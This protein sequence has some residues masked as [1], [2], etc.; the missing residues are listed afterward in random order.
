MKHEILLVDAE[1]RSVRVIGGALRTAGYNVRIAGNGV[2]ALEKVEALTPDVILSDAQLPKLH[3]YA[4]AAKLKERKASAHIPVV[5]LTPPGWSEE[6]GRG[7]E[8]GIADY[9][10]KPV[11]VRELIACV[12]LLV[13]RGARQRIAAAVS[14]PKSGR[15]SGSTKDMSVLDL[16]QT[17]EVLRA[18]GVAHV[19]RGESEAELS[20]RDGRAVDAKLGRLRGEE[21]IYAALVWS[22]ASFDVE[23]KAVSRDD[24]IDRSMGTL[25]V[26]GMRRIDEWSRIY[27]QLRPLT[28]IV[29]VDHARLLEQ[30]VSRLADD[31][32]LSSGGN[33]RTASDRRLPS[34]IADPM[35]AS[36]APPPRAEEEEEEEEERG[37]RR[38]RRRRSGTG[39]RR[40]Q[41]RC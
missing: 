36:H 13:A 31:K 35:H 34:V 17:F 15:L 11:F 27:E 41:E 12:G 5:L 6:R 40:P 33:E 26:E 9:L 22:E 37:R 25:L 29:E 28:T 39:E 30:A 32:A 18:S 21:A 3:G 7:R 14:A 8:L 4:L 38:G 10:A 16:L 2:E 1:R 24:V 23:F 20:F 19:R